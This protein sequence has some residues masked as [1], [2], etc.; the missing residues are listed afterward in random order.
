MKAQKFLNLLVVVLLATSLASC[1]GPTKIDATL[2]SYSITLSATSGRAGEFIFHVTN[3]ATDQKH[4]FVI[5]KT[6]LPIDQLP[7]KDDG[8][9]NMIVDEEG[10]GVTHIAEIAE[11]DA[12]T[13]QDLTVTLEPGNYIIVCNLAV[14]TTHYLHGMRIAF[15]VK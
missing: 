15:T 12:G 6:D 14:N 10:A 7:M 9:G 4:E 11:F 8:T 5:F 1:G 2:T 13:T 3:A